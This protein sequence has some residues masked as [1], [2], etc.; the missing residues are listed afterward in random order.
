M[1]DMTARKCAVLAAL[2]CAALPVS[3]CISIARQLSAG[4]ITYDE[5]VSPEQSALVVFSNTIR[6]TSY[7]GTNVDNKVWYPKAKIRINRV[8]LPARAATIHCDLLCDITRGRTIYHITYKNI[9]L[10]FKFEAGKEYTVSSYW[11]GS[12]GFTGLENIEFGVGIWEYASTNP[13]SQGTFL[14]AGFGNPDEA[15]E[16]WK[17]GDL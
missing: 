13:L 8:T 12:G 7:N 10:R 1:K 2:L 11:K 3:G 5:S 15:V 4:K 16:I 14:N 9:E 6:V 17:L